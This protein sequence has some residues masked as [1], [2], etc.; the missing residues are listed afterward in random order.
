MEPIE[1]LVLKYKSGLQEHLY[2][3]L[4]YMNITTIDVAYN[5]S[6]LVEETFL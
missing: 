5:K 2:R 4:T 6:Q 3:Q 1:K